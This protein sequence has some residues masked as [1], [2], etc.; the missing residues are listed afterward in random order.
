MKGGE[1]MNEIERPK[2]YEILRNW[3]IRNGYTTPEWQMYVDAVSTQD[4][5]LFIAFALLG[6]VFGYFI[7]KHGF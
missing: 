4:M 7:G 2:F 6:A 5:L 1:N 3:R